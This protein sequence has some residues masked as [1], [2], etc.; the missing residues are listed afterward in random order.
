MRPSS[1]TATSQPW[2]VAAGAER[3]HRH[4][5][6]HHGDVL[7][8]QE[9]D[10]DAPVQGI[11]LALVGEQLDDDDGAREGQR[12]GDVERLDQV[13]TERQDEQKAEDDGEGELAQAGRQ[14]HL[15]DVAHAREIEL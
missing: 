11:Q 2:R 15:A 3:A 12:D 7:H 1:E 10:R 14:R 5:R 4:H 8:D 6:H 13:L 9:A